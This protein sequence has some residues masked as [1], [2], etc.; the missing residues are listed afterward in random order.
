MGA[1]YSREA[2]DGTVEHHDSK[3]SL[4]QAKRRENSDAT[5]GLFGMIGLL[6]GGVFTYL[7]FLK[8]GGMDWPK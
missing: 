7:V 6:C 4:E 2:A 3:E 5:A 1:R 8:F